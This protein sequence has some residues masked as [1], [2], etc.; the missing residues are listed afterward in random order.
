MGGG[1]ALGARSEA[2]S[3]TATLGHRNPPPNSPHGMS[4]CPIL[5]AG[6]RGLYNH[7][8][9]VPQPFLAVSEPQ[10]CFG[11]SHWPESSRGCSIAYAH[12]SRNREGIRCGLARACAGKDG[13][14]FNTDHITAHERELSLELPLGG[15][16]SWRD[17]STRCHAAW[18]HVPLLDDSQT[19]TFKNLVQSPHVK[20]A[21][22]DITMVTG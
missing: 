14:R 8:S 18:P 21:P 2:C 5:V 11:G 7:F 1:R 9:F 19:L 15:S 20:L 3:L 13:Q 12:A 10:K 22:S 16:R 4:G 17:S 6:M